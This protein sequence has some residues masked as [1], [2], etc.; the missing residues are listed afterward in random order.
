MPARQA[1]AVTGSQCGAAL[2]FLEQKNRRTKK[3]EAGD[4]EEEEEE[5]THRDSPPL[6]VRALLMAT[7]VEA[8]VA[9]HTHEH[10]H[11][12]GWSWIK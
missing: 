3:E 4:E 7:M 11:T 10:A 12:D 8:R 9:R 2:D 6:R 5:L 1:R